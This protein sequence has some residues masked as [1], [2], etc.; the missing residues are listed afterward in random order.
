MVVSI[1]ILCFS[2][3]D[4]LHDLLLSIGL[5]FQQGEL[6]IRLVEP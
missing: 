1:Q 6:Q 4:I 5:V 3:V 2:V